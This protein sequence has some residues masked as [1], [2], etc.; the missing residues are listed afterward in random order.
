MKSL[1]KSQSPPNKENRKSLEAQRRSFES[2]RPLTDFSYSQA[3]DQPH[4]EGRKSLEAQRRSFESQRPLAELSNSQTNNGNGTEDSTSLQII[5]S[6]IKRITARNLDAY[7]YRTLQQTVA[8]DIALLTPTKVSQL[9]GA[10]LSH[11]SETE[12]PSDNRILNQQLAILRTIQNGKT[13]VFSESILECMGSI[14]IA[15]GR[16]PEHAHAQVAL[17]RSFREILGDPALPLVEATEVLIALT[18]C[19]EGMQH[20][21]DPVRRMTVYLEA[22]ITVLKLSGRSLFDA[23]SERCAELVELTVR[24]MVHKAPSIRDTS[25]QLAIAIRAQFGDRD[26]FLSSLE[27]LTPH[28]EAM[29]LYYIE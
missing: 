18:S 4:R 14:V 26:D 19:A 25:Y 27:D 7:G 22:L 16:Y 28:I 15:M 2:Q 20:P 3:K 5:N 1:P 21:P 13:Q 11:L 29:L 10:V 12:S 9:L 8:R 23:R 17:S 24:N 6:G